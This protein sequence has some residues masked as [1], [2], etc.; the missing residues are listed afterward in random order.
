MPRTTKFVVFVL[1]L[2]LSLYFLYHGHLITGLAF[3]GM[4][5]LIPAS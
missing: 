3:F 1:A 2:V 4:A 5:I